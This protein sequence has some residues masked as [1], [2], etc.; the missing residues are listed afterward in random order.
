MANNQSP[1]Q[2]TG[3]TCTTSSVLG[4]A[5]PTHR[6][7]HVNYEGWTQSRAVI[8]DSDKETVLYRVNLKTCWK[9]L[10]SGPYLTISTADTNCI[11]GTVTFHTLSS[12]IDLIIQ[13]Q[14]T[15]LSKA[16]F[17]TNTHGFKSSAGFLKWKFDGMLSCGNML[18]VD[19]KEQ[20]FARF[21]TGGW[22]L[23]KAG[24]F[25]LSPGLGDMIM[26]EV[27]VSGIAMVEWW[28]LQTSVTV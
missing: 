2:Q 7:L 21:Q 26:D 4:N 14:A 16:R 12:K 15:K 10:S 20:L 6:L 24:R 11:V 23:K 1:A 5:A 8:L 22:S 18:C 13:N 9:L 27:I 28:R 25:E 17:F 3:Y 19:E